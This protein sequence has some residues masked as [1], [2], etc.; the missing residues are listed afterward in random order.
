MNNQLIKFLD[1]LETNTTLRENFKNAKSIEEAFRVSQN[2]LYGI[3]LDEFKKL[4][5]FVV[6]EINQSSTGLYTLDD[7]ELNAIVGG[8]GFGEVINYLGSHKKHVAI[9]LASILSVGTV[10][11][12]M[13]MNEPNENRNTPE[14]YSVQ[15]QNEIPT[16]TKSNIDNNIALEAEKQKLAEEQKKEQDRQTAIKKQAEIEK[17]K[18]AEVAKQKQAEAAKQQAAK[19]SS[20]SINMSCLLQ[21]PDLPTGC[22]ATS[23][24]MVL[25]HYGYNIDKVSLAKNFLPKSSD[26]YNANGKDYGVDFNTTFAGDPTSANAYGCLAPAIVTTA[27]NYLSQNGRGDLTVS[28]ISGSSPS[29]LY[30]YV[31]KGTPVI[32]WATMNMREPGKGKSW[33]APNGNLLTWPS[34]EHCLVLI[35][36]NN[37]SVILNDPLKGTTTYSRSLFEQRYSQMGSQAVVLQK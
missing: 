3:T 14:S 17:Q 8:I 29:Q 20:N 23:L 5:L 9:S 26:F 28:N 1:E 7:D 10:F 4:T 16:S 15:L 2:Y 18:Q 30:D 12:A 31:N 19:S 36:Y 37:D 24:T 13:K 6:K 27:N 34:G 22:E 35:G 33:Y 21:N 11:A 32:V 25:N